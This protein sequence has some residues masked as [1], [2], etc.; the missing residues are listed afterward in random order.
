MYCLFFIRSSADGHLGCFHV[1]ALVNSA[2]MNIGVHVSF[3]IR[4]FSV[5]TPRSGIAG[6]YGHSI[7][8]L[9]LFVCLFLFFVFLGMHLGHR[10]F[11]S[12]GRIRAV[13]T[14][15]YQATAMPNLSRV[16]SIHY[17]SWQ[18][19]ILN[20][21]SKARDWTHVLMDASQIHFHWA[22]RTPLYLVFK[23]PP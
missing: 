9:F 20:P 11:Q 7:F 10:G 12:R 15:L 21:L 2:A 13:A 4:V 23:E 22:T 19:Q 16:C 8:R 14:G 6:W 5:Y 3:R 18:C 1:L 17:S